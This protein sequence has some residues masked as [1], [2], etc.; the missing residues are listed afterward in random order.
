MP[1]RFNRAALNLDLD[2]I[3]AGGGVKRKGKPWGRKGPV[4][5]T[6]ARLWRPLGVEVA[7]IIGS[8]SSLCCLLFGPLVVY[9]RKGESDS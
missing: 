1:V 5:L 8:S 6:D 2:F 4:D 3:V 9:D 7:Q